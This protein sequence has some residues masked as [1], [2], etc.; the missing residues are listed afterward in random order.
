LPDTKHDWSSRQ[1][2]HDA[3]WDQAV[4]RKNGNFLVT[5]SPG[6]LHRS[7]QK[8]TRFQVA[9][10]L[11]QKNG[12]EITW[13]NTFA[14][15]P[16]SVTMLTIPGPPRINET[17]QI[18]NGAPSYDQHGFNPA[19]LV[20]AVNH[21]MPMGKVKAIY[22]LREFLKIARDSHFARETRID[23]DIDTSD[24]TCVFLIVR[25]LFEPLD[26]ARELPPILTVPF[27]PEPDEGDKIFWPLH[28]VFLQD[29]V[30][31]FLVYGGGMGGQ[32]QEPDVHLNWAEQYGK[33]RT[34]PLRPINNPMIAAE[35]LASLEQTKRLYDDPRSPDF[36][37]MFYEQA[38]NIIVDVDPELSKHLPVLRADACDDPDWNERVKAVSNLKMHWSE[39]TQ[40]YLTN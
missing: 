15:L 14:V 4:I 9:L 36:K 6:M 22:E 32:T 34:K 26:P 35:R 28:P 18:I 5:V 2:R 23:E 29:D 20:R 25:L 27:A 31:F 7:V 38:W 17:M 12:K 40:R 19:K 1:E 10:S 21:L 24:K 39:A 8:E 3:V 16:Q 11:G 33:I 13:R 30:P 37:A